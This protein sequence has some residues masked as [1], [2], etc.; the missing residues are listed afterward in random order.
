MKIL[1]LFTYG[2][3]LKNWSDSGYISREI[4][5]FKKMNESYGV[6]FSLLTFGDSN[7]LNLL[8]QYEYLEV[9]PIYKYLNKKKNKF[10][11][12]FYILLNLKKILINLNLNFDLI[13]TNQ[14]F[15]SWI[16]I[17][18]KIFFKKPLILRTGYDLFLF[19]IKDRKNIFKIIAYYF[20][21]LISLNISDLYTV[22]SQSDMKFISKFY[23][24]KKNKLVLRRNWVNNISENKNINNIL[25][26]QDNCLS[27]GRL[28]IQKDF[29]YLIRSF[30]SSSFNLDI[31]GE[32]SLLPNL[33]NISNENINF[34]GNIEFSHLEDLYSEYIFF[35]S[36]TNYEGNPKS[37]LEAMSKG[38]IVIAPDIPNISEII[39]DKSN[40]ILYDKKLDDVHSI[41]CNL[42]KDTD[43]L[44][45]ISKNAI[46]Y[47]KTNN[48]LDLF[49]KEEFGDYEL[50]IAN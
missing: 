22:T 50:V 27:V 24:F 21:T 46:S 28:E 5:F 16:A 17:Y 18:L 4:D 47:V 1:F 23:V 44:M 25:I 2:T 8:S 15:G 30:N 19:S 34:L 45:E 29:E 7:D 10:L 11:N 38:C 37:I 6:K 13:K 39:K 9:I 43:K 14:L 35:V 48:S 31:V 12:F 40:G 42:K 20:L 26:E 32:G 49:T 33:K 41:I 3:S 36:A